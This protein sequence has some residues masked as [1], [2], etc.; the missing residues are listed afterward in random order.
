[1]SAPNKHHFLYDLSPFG[2]ANDNEV[3]NA[4]DRPYGL[5]QASVTRDDASDAGPAWDIAG[6]FA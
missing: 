2:V 6:G 1:M 5:I 3:Y 4:D